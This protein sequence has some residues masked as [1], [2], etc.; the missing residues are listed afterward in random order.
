[1]KDGFKKKKLLSK[2][3]QEYHQIM[4]LTSMGQLKTFNIVQSNLNKLSHNIETVGLSNALMKVGRPYQYQ[5]SASKQRKKFSTL[6]DGQEEAKGLEPKGKAL[7]GPS[8]NLSHG[9]NQETMPQVEGRVLTEGN[10]T[11]RT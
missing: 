3:G 2:S 9:I 7:R 5:E 1:M 8:F 11:D 4:P 6:S 10:D